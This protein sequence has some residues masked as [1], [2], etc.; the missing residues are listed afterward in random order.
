MSVGTD[1][2]V[3]VCNP[4]VPLS[5]INSLSLIDSYGTVIP[6][7]FCQ[8]LDHQNVINCCDICGDGSTLIT[9]S[10]DGTPK[11]WDIFFNEINGNE[12]ID[13]FSPRPRSGSEYPHIFNDSMFLD[14]S[15]H[16][17]EGHRHLSSSEPQ[18][19][20]KC[21]AIS[22]N[23]R[24]G[25]LVASG[26]NDLQ[27]HIWR[28]SDLILL[29]TLTPHPYPVLSCHFSNDSTRVITASG[30]EVFLF[31]RI[32]GSKIRSLKHEKNVEN[33]VFGPKLDYVFTSSGKYV[34]KWSSSLPNSPTKFNSLKTKNFVLT[35]CAVSPDS[36]YVAG[37]TTTDQVVIWSLS[38]FATVAVATFK[39]ADR[40]NC[41]NFDRESTKLLS[42]LDDGAVVI[43]DTSKTFGASMVA[44]RKKFSVQNQRADLKVLTPD[45]NGTLRLFEGIEGKAIEVNMS[46]F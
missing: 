22:T 14:D 16:T 30:D 4:P 5:L 34:F 9:A 36:K 1:K 7:N 35:H 40:I 3:K 46:Q 41:I 31:D 26:D 27:V 23:T 39:C 15:T 19:E 24:E 11:V 29:Q 2:V 28:L 43:W 38:A 18:I 13:V 44:L 45:E 12:N 25:W 37:S 20:V 10:V 21:C 6:E 42:C 32:N 33:C 17:Y 8:L